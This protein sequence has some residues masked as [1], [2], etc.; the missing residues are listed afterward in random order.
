VPDGVGPEHRDEHR[1][2]EERG[3]R[4][5]PERRGREAP[6]EL[7]AIA[8]ARPR[9]EEPLEVARG[10]DELVQERAERAEQRFERAALVVPRRVRALHVER[11]VIARA[12]ELDLRLGVGD[13]RGVQVERREREVGEARGEGQDGAAARRH[14]ER[15]ARVRSAHELGFELGVLAHDG[16]LHCGLGHGPNVPL[17]AMAQIRINHGSTHARDPEAAARH[18]A[19]LVGGV[20]APFHPCE[21]AWVAF[22]GP[23]EDW[24]GPLVELYPATMVLARLGGRAD[25]VPRQGDAPFPHGTHF[26]VSVPRSRAE[27][28]AVCAERGL[29]CSWRGWANL[30]EVWVED[31][32]LF[33]LV[34]A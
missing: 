3:E 33:E 13:L 16:E 31:D 18:L 30:L 29:A 1:G 11:A 5:R 19:A 23:K 7:G 22:F 15:G 9:G 32:L 28:E 8:L 4:G 25:F 6:D 26:N 27:L 21:G 20:A 14:D 34:P 10:R 2:L 24:E 17:L 12:H